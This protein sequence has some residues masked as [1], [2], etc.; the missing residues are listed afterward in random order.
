[1]LVPW[2]QLLPQHGLPLLWQLIV[3]SS[4]WKQK[5]APSDPVMYQGLSI[6]HQLGKLL[7]LSY[8]YHLDTKTHCHG[9]M[10]EK[11]AGFHLGYHVEDH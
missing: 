9:W 4:V 7:A 11:Q 8:L 6:L 3:I 10:A 1:M 5:G 2:L